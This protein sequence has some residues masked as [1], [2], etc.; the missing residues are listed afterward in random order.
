[1]WEIRSG[2]VTEHTQMLQVDIPSPLEQ[3]RSRSHQ[4]V[5]PQQILARSITAVTNWFMFINCIRE[6]RQDDI[7]K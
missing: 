4:V 7:V 2:E 1:M 3:T 5:R 6:G